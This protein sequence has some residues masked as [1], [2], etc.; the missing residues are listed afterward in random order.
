MV[1][2]MKLL[3]LS[4]V[5]CSLFSVA[6]SAGSQ[7]P[8]DE[9]KTVRMVVAASSAG[10]GFDVDSRAIS[11][12]MDR[13]VCRGNPAAIVENM[14]GAGSLAAANHIFKVAKPDGLTHREHQRWYPCSS[15]LWAGPELEFDAL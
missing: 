2:L 5:A 8:F 15:S 12:H 13:S 10:G 3:K 1:N 11:R 9:G 6:A 7:E 14:T 4:L